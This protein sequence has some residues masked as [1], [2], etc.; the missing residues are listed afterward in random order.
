M[1]DRPRAARCSARS[2]TARTSAR[3]A[4]DRAELLE[5]R[6]RARRDDPRERRLARARG[7][8]EEHRVRAALLDRG[9]QRRAR[10]RA[11]APGLRSPRGRGGA[12]SRRAAA[13]AA[14]RSAAGREARSRGLASS[15]NRVSILLSMQTGDRAVSKLQREVAFEPRRRCRFGETLKVRHTTQRRVG[16]R[17][18][19]AVR[20][21]SRS[22]ATR[23]RS[24]TSSTSE[25]RSQRDR[26]CSCSGG[27]CARTGS[28]SSPAVSSSS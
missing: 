20:R 9:A 13:A 19:S 28:R 24:S 1:R 6:S 23:T 2:I 17:W 3:P 22:P 7:P 8:V 4:C 18:P 14:G 26:R 12:P 11:D 25:A 16:A 5:G 10:A 15:P 27:G 21:R